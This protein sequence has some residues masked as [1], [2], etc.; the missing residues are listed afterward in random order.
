MGQDPLRCGVELVER[1]KADPVRKMWVLAGLAA[2]AA[3]HGDCELAMAIL[4]KVTYPEQRVYAIESVACRCSETRSLLREAREIISRLPPQCYVSRA[5]PGAIFNVCLEAKEFDQALA[6]CDSMQSPFDEALYTAE[7]VARLGAAQPRDEML[8]LLQ[9]ARQLASRLND[10]DDRGTVLNQIAD[11]YVELDANNEW[12]ATLDAIESLEYRIGPLAAMAVRTMSDDLFTELANTVPQAACDWEL[13]DVIG[14]CVDT[15]HREAA[16]RLLS[17]MQEG[18]WK[19]SATR[20][21]MGAGN[22][23]KANAGDGF[24]ARAAQYEAAGDATSAQTEIRRGF[25]A[26][27]TDSGLR[28]E[29][30]RTVAEAYCEAGQEFSAGV[31][32]LL[33]QLVES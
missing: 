30:L 22:T 27:A 31:V 15:G 21:M 32:S 7:L 9:R 1:S 33:E 25:T 29:A 5:E 8:R 23:T 3:R 17:L 4:A 26:L 6:V 24:A 16:S 19:D 2:A 10:P 12:R 14:R 20:K 11:A 28:L 13:E 18:P